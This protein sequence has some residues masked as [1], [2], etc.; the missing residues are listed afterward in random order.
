MKIFK[1]KNNDKGTPILLPDTNGMAAITA[2]F[3]VYALL[4]YLGDSF[5]K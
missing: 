2:L 1:D 5:Q 4:I 3:V